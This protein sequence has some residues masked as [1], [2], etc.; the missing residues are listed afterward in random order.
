MS[1]VTAT[2]RSTGDAEHRVLEAKLRLREVED[3]EK[4]LRASRLYNT[5]LLQGLSEQRD[6]VENLIKV[7]EA[8]L[9]AVQGRRAAAEQRREQLEQRLARESTPVR[10]CSTTYWHRMRIEVN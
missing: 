1:S 3:E 5:E 9:A 6:A 10:K 7:V 4:S 8:R 2:I